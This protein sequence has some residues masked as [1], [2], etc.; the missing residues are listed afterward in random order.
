MSVIESYKALSD[1]SRLRILHALKFG[2]LSVQDLTRIVKLGQSTVSHHLKILTQAGMVLSEKTGT[3]IFYR[4]S[5]IEETAEHKNAATYLTHQFVNEVVGTLANG[6]GEK[7]DLDTVEIKKILA[8]KRDATKNFFDKVAPAWK[9]MREQIQG[10][11]LFFTDILK[12]IRR[13]DTLL[14]LG[15]G[16]GS[17][18]DA[19][20]PRPGNTIA[21]DY[22]EPMLDVTKKNLGTKATGVDLRLGYLEHLPIAN[23]SIDTAVSYMVLHHISEPAK[24]LQDVFR[25]VK[26]GGRGLIVELSRHDTQGLSDQM[27]DAWSGFTE[28]E[29]SSWLTDAGFN[30]PS[31]KA[32]SEKVFLTIGVKP[33]NKK[34]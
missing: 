6:L 5:P 18:L 25:V 30:S 13:E 19:A 29:L 16:A 1:E 10:A 23:E 31:T 2:R 7:F 26:P 8:E 28:A 11:D 12:L 20:L 32:L 34:E 15:C 22:S 27:A 17:F 3:W 33:E 4:L 24:V 14:E 9:T 21:V